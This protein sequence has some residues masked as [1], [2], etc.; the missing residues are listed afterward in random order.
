VPH[1]GIPYVTQVRHDATPGRS[2]ST[3]N[4]VR[5]RTTTLAC[6]G[7]FA[8]AV[9]PPA[10]DVA[11]SCGTSRGHVVWN[12]CSEDSKWLTQGVADRVPVQHHART[13]GGGN[14]VAGRPLP[15]RLHARPIRK[16]ESHPRFPRDPH[17]A[18]QRS[19]TS[20]PPGLTAP[21]VILASEQEHD[22][23]SVE[24]PFGSA[25][26]GFRQSGTRLTEADSFSGVA[27]PP[28]AVDVPLETQSH[29]RKYPFSAL[30]T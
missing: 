27:F 21:T 19:M 29:G 13:L 25:E 2:T 23:A 1:E 17:R 9:S 16:Y 26:I 7:S 15:Q 28:R 11:T 14:R 12:E 18:Q 6:S 22:H 10:I 4:S 8:T 3:S 30:P 5:R 24:L 20:V